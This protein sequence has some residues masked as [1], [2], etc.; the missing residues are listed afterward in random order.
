M[1]CK[2]CGYKVEEKSFDS[3]EHVHKEGISDNKAESSTCS[4]KLRKG[5]DIDALVQIYSSYV[6]A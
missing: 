6:Q 3:T 5:K 1:A 2:S 4:A